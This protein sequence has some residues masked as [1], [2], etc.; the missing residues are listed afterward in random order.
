MKHIKTLGSSIFGYTV[1]EEII[2]LN[3]W[4]EVKLSEDAIE[5]KATEYYTLAEAEDFIS[6]LVDHVDRQLILAL[7]CF[8]ALRPNEIAALRWEDFDDEWVHIRHGVVRGSV[9]VPKTPE[10][11]ASLPLIGQI[12]VPQST[13]FPGLVARIHSGPISNNSDTAKVGRSSLGSA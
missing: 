4:R 1:A 11:I 6:A 13:K 2:K 8:L 7:S 10:S 3:P 9:D 12:L 5:S